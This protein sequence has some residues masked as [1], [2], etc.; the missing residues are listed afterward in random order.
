MKNKKNLLRTLA[1]C[2][3]LSMGIGY[4]VVSEQTLTYTETIPVGERKLNVL[5]NDSKA[6]N[7]GLT[8]SVTQETTILEEYTVDD[9]YC[10][11]ILIPIANDEMELN[12]LIE[13]TITVKSNTGDDIPF[14]SSQDA[15][16]RSEIEF[17][18]YSNILPAGSSMDYKID[19][20]INV[21]ELVQYESF[22][23]TITFTANPT[24]EL[25]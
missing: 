20:S 14:E 13:A 6:T 10:R 12:A 1:L 22:V 21:S 11:N 19:L 5:I 18:G 15:F 16:F 3:T 8:L 23:I 9:E 2:G 7:E 17:T 4:A 25:Y 24:T